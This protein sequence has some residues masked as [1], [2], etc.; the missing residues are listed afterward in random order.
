MGCERAGLDPVQGSNTSLWHCRGG[1]DPAHHLWLKHV[2]KWGTQNGMWSKGPLSAYL[3]PSWLDVVIWTLSA[4]FSRHERHWLFQYTVSLQLPDAALR[5]QTA[6]Q[7]LFCFHIFF[8][9]FI[10]L[11]IDHSIYIS[12]IVLQLNLHC[13]FAWMYPHIVCQ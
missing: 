3:R 6:A 5:L 11:N 8:M 9:S 4:L 2:M 13:S 12:F 1:H 10:D 7:S